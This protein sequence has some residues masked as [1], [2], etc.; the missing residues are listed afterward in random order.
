MNKKLSKE[1]FVFLL[2]LIGND[3]QR[4]TNRSFAIS[5]EIQI[6]VTLRYYATGT[7]QGWRTYGTRARSGTLTKFQWHYEKF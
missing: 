3:L 5:P 2:N 7:F 6:L 1:T 4:S